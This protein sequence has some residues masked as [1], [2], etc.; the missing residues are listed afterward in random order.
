MKF[1]FKV[2][3]NYIAIVRDLG[4]IRDLDIDF[5][6]IGGG[7]NNGKVISAVATNY[8]SKDNF[9]EAIRNNFE[10][11]MSLE[12]AVF[13]FEEGSYKAGWG[14]RIS[15]RFVGRNNRGIQDIFIK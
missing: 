15:I 5:V 7:D 3:D 12:S 8:L 11:M 9:I 4:G 6:Q 1:S 14:T 2:N 13:H 10:K